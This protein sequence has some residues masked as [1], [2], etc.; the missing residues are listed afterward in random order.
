MKTI[1]AFLLPY[2]KNGEGPCPVAVEGVQPGGEAYGDHRFA[3]GGTP[4]A[5][6][7]FPCRL[8]PKGRA[9]RKAV[10][11]AGLGPQRSPRCLP[12]PSL[13]VSIFIPSGPFASLSDRGGAHGDLLGWGTR[14]H[15]RSRGA[16]SGSAMP[17]SRRAPC[18]LVES[19]FA[20]NPS[21]PSAPTR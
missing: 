7:C 18:M 10:F 16:A 6:R 17:A 8:G 9:A 5:R 14:R 13:T 15:F 1:W 11:L 3:R 4:R 19:S 21:V 2:E 20:S 12:A